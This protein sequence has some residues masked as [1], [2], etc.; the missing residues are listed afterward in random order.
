M[1]TPPPGT[2]SCLFCAGIISVKD[3]SDYKFRNHMQSIHE[4]FHNFEILFSL[5][6]LRDNETDYI[7]GTIKNRIATADWGDEPENKE[8]IQYFEAEDDT[9]SNTA[10]EQVIIGEE[11][12]TAEANVHHQTPIK[13]VKTLHAKIQFLKKENLKI[14]QDILKKDQILE[15][16][17]DKT[18]EF[19]KLE[20][21][22]T[23]TKTKS[24]KVDPLDGFMCEN[25]RKCFR[26]K[27]S[28][29][30]H[31]ERTTRCYSKDDLVCTKC[32]KIFKY[33]AQLAEHK[34]R[35][36]GCVKTVPQC[37]KC[38]KIFRDKR[39]FENHMKRKFSCVKTILQCEKCDK[40]FKERKSFEFHMNK[41]YDCKMEN[42]RVDGVK[43]N[44]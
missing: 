41:K 22:E 11:E 29:T 20:T 10:D 12:E 34:E 37:E 6:F 3:G 16:A 35:K 31:L 26:N 4:V 42:W 27:Y 5:H 13:N 2:I 17:V 21:T 15:D 40:I 25:C 32:N 36:F 44:E 30:M 8:L 39:Q 14:K 28:F 19:A 18:S 24:G 23:K 33:Y 38:K 7:N 9:I 1:L 43:V